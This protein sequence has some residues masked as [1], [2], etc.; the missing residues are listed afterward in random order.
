MEVEQIQGLSVV[1][2]VS[3]YENAEQM[4]RS[5]KEGDYVACARIQCTQMQT[6]CVEKGLSDGD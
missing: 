4:K 6:F 1:T 3:E 2:L 5:M